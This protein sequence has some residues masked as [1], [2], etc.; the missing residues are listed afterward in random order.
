M[1]PW[2]V[3]PSTGPRPSAGDAARLREQ[4]CEMT[5]L[6]ACLA[7]KL[8]KHQRLL[9]QLL[10]IQQLISS[11]AALPSILDEIVAGA[12]AL[13]GDEAGNIRLQ[14]PA[15]PERL[16]LAGRVSDPSAHIAK[17]DSI[18]IGEGATGR[19]FTEERLVVIEDYA[20]AAAA[21]PAY[22]TS[23]LEACMAAPVRQNG[24]VIGVMVVATQK[25][26]RTYSEEE[27]EILL[28]FAEHASLALT[29][30]QRLRAVEHMA[31][32]DSLTG[33]VNRAHF[34]E[35]LDQA[36]AQSRRT[37]RRVAVLFIDLD[38]FKVINDSLGHAFGD[39]LLEVVARRLGEAVRV[40][41]VTARLGGDEFA[42]LLSET[43]D[44]ASV[45][46]VVER[47][48][49]LLNAPATVD[50]HVVPVQ[51]SVGTAI[52]DGEHD[53]AALLRNADLAMYAAKTRGGCGAATY[54]VSMH[55][56]QESRSTGGRGRIG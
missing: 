52:S 49:S 53:A 46:Q 20:H 26:G 44:D 32:H 47:L 31:Y 42:V 12:T 41:D 35:R 1:A 11:S 4:L 45:A 43:N 40:D 16:V 38:G 5:R 28:A 3:P 29:S 23:K 2:P 25:K 54:D 19:A 14:D 6:N 27:Q 17:V 30:A 10:L 34:L 39:R 50:G 8:E 22:G 18:R 24:Q 55:A 15:D 48:L 37:S 13:I 51:A 7:A 33:L 36:L 9:H 21:N 56:R